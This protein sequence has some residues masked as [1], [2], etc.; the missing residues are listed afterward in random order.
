MK[1]SILLSLLIL[2]SVLL[3]NCQVTVGQEYETHAVPVSQDYSDAIDAAT[4]EMITD[5]TFMD[6]FFKLM[7][8]QV[9]QVSTNVKY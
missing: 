2:C 5:T 9:P 4:Q 1:Y 6:A 8:F 7:Y 3:L